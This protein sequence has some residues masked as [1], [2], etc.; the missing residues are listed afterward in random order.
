MSKPKKKLYLLIPILNYIRKLRLA[1]NLIIFLF[2]NKLKRKFFFSPDN[3]VLIFS[4]KFLKRE[5]ILF[6]NYFTDIFFRSVDKYF[7]KKISKV[8]LKRKCK[9]FD[10]VSFHKN[11]EESKKKFHEMFYLQKIKS[12]LEKLALNLTKN[13]LIFKKFR[14]KK[15]TKNILK[16]IEE[17]IL[18]LYFQRIILTENLVMNFLACYFL[19]FL[20]KK[21][22]V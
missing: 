12:F 13:F 10:I 22:C 6:S 3:F 8:F 4:K 2:E 21:K 15:I 16:F 14:Y 18:G 7:F 17:K 11:I 19:K 1:F 20:S 9:I 5:K